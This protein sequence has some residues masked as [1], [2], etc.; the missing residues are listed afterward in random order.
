MPCS[1]PHCLASCMGATWQGGGPYV[2][3]WALVSAALDGAQSKG[4]TEICPLRWRL[5]L[6]GE[7]RGAAADPNAFTVTALFVKFIGMKR[8]TGFAGGADSK[9]CRKA[10]SWL[11]PS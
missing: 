3:V 8:T 2:E 7:C 4:S 11:I 10:R 9:V 6:R 5:S 1:V